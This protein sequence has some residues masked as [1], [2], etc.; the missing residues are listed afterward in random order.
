MNNVIT[1]LKSSIGGENE[2]EVMNEATREILSV[3]SN[4]LTES[5]LSR[6]N[7]TSVGT[8]KKSIFRTNLLGV[9]KISVLNQNVQKSKYNV[10]YF[11]NFLAC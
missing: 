2:S 3:V 6:S 1:T 7:Q 5:Q 4:I 11:V 10:S 8:G 9:L